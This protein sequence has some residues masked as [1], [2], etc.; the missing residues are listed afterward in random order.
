MSFINELKIRAKKFKKNGKPKRKGCSGCKRESELRKIRGQRKEY[1]EKIGREKAREYLIKEGDC[2]AEC[3]SI[4]NGGICPTCKNC[5]K[6]KGYYKKDELKQ[7]DKPTQEMIEVMYNKKTGYLR[8][9][10]C[11][12]PRPMRSFT[13]LNHMCKYEF[14]KERYRIK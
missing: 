12:L 11:C 8:D 9:I 13:C 6:N 4:K 10:G 2:D 7:F 3:N 5:G 14:N 1:F